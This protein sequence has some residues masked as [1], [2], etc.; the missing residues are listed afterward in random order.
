MAEPNHPSLIWANDFLLDNGRRPTQ[1]AP[2]GGIVPIRRTSDTYP[3]SERE[4]LYKPLISE[5]QKDVDDIKNFYNADL[6]NSFH[7]KD[8]LQINPHSYDDH[9]SVRK[10]WNAEDDT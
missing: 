7:H 1:L 4:Q 10:E 2:H 8:Y 5:N 9:V 6:A 3:Q